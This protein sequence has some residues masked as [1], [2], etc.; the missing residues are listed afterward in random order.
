MSLAHC[1]ECNAFL[2]EH[3]SCPHISSNLRSPPAQT[4]AGA[5]R[6]LVMASARTLSTTENR[7]AS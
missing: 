4:S 1:I 7:K 3:E 6:P 5:V 2:A